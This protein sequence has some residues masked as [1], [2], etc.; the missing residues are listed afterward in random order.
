MKVFPTTVETVRVVTGSVYTSKDPL[1]DRRTDV[2]V[3]STNV[4][5]LTVNVKLRTTVYPRYKLACNVNTDGPPVVFPDNVRTPSELMPT[6]STVPLKVQFEMRLPL[7]VW[8]W[9]V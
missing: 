5:A 3:G 6:P 2:N 9:I 7:Y 8:A 4:P 1:S